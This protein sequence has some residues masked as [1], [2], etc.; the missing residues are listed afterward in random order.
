MVWVGVYIY[1]LIIRTLD[2]V[3]RVDNQILIQIILVQPLTLIFLTLITIISIQTILS[4][5]R[6]VCL[7]NYTTEDLQQVVSGGELQV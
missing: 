5:V 6:K 3:K 4:V 2:Q 7:V 1:D